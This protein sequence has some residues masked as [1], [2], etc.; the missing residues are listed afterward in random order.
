MEKPQLVFQ[1]NA[2]KRLN[3]IM[4]PKAIIEKW[5][6]NFYMSIYEDKIVLEPIKNNK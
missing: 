2:D 6:R 4:L 1:K 5:G 3:R